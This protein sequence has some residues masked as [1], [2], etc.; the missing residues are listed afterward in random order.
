MSRTYLYAISLTIL[1]GIALL[2]LL[3]FKLVERFESSGSTEEDTINGYI[4]TISESVCPA[5]LFML[6]DAVSQMRIK[7]TEEEK[8]KKGT[9]ALEIDAGGPLFP[10]PPP[11]D[12]VNVPANINVRIQRTVRYLYRRLKRAGEKV[13]GAMNCK[14]KS[15]SQLDDEKQKEEKEDQD[16]RQEPVYDD[17]G[18][19]QNADQYKQPISNQD[20][21]AILKLRVNTLTQSMKNPGVV[22]QLVAVKTMTDGLMAMKKAAQE[23]KIRPTCAKEGEDESDQVQFN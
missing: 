17:S 7:G 21:T 14:R 22:N 8:H 23:N 4:T 12:P 9:E 1:I 18:S 5:L 20:R 2:I 6:N 11:S 19:L 15:E 16:A 13:Q 3:S 10:C